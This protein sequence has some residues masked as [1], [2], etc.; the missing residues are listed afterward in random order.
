MQITLHSTCD[1]WL[2]AAGAINLSSIPACA[3]SF[4]GLGPPPTLHTFICQGTNEGISVSVCL[5]DTELHVCSAFPFLSFFFLNFCRSRRQLQKHRASCWYSVSISLP[6]YPAWRQL[7]RN[8][9]WEY[10]YCAEW[11]S[12]HPLV[13]YTRISCTLHFRGLLNS[14][15]SCHRVKAGQT[16]NKSPVYSATP[17]NKSLFCTQ[18][19]W[20]RTKLFM[21]SFSYFFSL[22]V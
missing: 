6:R 17:K 16:L 13:P 21:Y 11:V 5:A 10:A 18:H 22:V 9:A 2:T 8:T 19:F 14:N 15:T 7:D 4:P 12:I 1:S 20:V 3:D